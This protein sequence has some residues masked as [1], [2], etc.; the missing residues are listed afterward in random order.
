M[1]FDYTIIWTKIL[2]DILL[3]GIIFYLLFKFLSEE[4]IKL[5][6]LMLSDEEIYWLNEK[7]VKKILILIYF[8]LVFLIIINNINFNF[9]DTKNYRK[10]Q[11]FYNNKVYIERNMTLPKKVKSFNYENEYNK[12]DEEITKEQNKNHKEMK[13]KKW[14]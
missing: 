3:L 13:W 14:F 8:V 1:N 7:I 5:I 4:R 10:S 11:N 9:S 6:S 12:I 2:P